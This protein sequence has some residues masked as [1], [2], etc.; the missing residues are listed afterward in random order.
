MPEGKPFIRSGE[1]FDC[2]NPFEEGESV[3][4]LF[5]DSMNEALHW[6][7][8]NCNDYKAF[9]SENGLVDNRLQYLPEQIPPILTDIFKKYKLLSVPEKQIKF[10]IS[11][12]NNDCTENKLLLDARSHK[13]ILKI[14]E[15]LFDYFGF[16]EHNQKV[17]YLCFT[18][19]SKYETELNGNFYFNIL[20]D[21]TA[22]RSVYYAIRFNKKTS[23]FNFDLD[24]AAKKI[25][26]FSCHSEPVRIIGSSYYLKQICDWFETHDLSLKLNKKSCVFI[27]DEP[28]IIFNKDNNLKNRIEKLFNILSEKIRRILIFP[29]QGIPYIECKNGCFHMPVY[30]KAM[31][32]EPESLVSLDDGYEG[33]LGLMT[34]YLT[35]FPGIS[36]LTTYKSVIED[37]NCGIGSKT[38]RIIDSGIK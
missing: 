34:P 14:Y 26:D 25:I 18:Y 22:H 16:V 1:L 4:L 9:L 17:N 30:A 32:F 3:D 35:S 21:L 20:T 36:L 33:I 8:S 10:K 6:H 5:N 13:R 37:C 38:F 12:N 29:Y 7:L 2:L 31:T 15:K 11:S 27:I 19:D 28:D 24:A 23:E